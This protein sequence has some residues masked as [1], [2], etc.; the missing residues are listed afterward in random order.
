MTPDHPVTQ[1]RGART[2]PYLMM[3]ALLFWGWQSGYWQAG[4]VM[5]IVLEGA[6][7][8]RTRWDVSEEDFRR[9]RN[10]CALLGLALVVYIFSTNEAGGGV[11]SLFGANTLA[12]TRY[13]G[14]SAT[15][16]LRW[17]PIVL[18]LFVAAEFYSERQAVPLVAISWFLRNLRKVRGGSERTMDI[19]YPYF[20][21]CLFSASIHM[22]EGDLSYFWGQS[23]LVAWALWP[24]RTVRF[25]VVAWG[26]ALAAAIGL[27]LV[28]QRGL[29]ELQR[30]IEGY[31]AQ[32]MANLMRPRTIPAQ[33]E[34]AM[35][36][37]GKLKLSPRI[38]IRLET[39]TGPA[40]DYL[41]EATY[42]RYN[43]QQ[44]AWHAGIGRTDF[45]NVP[46]EPGNETAW[47][48][49]RGKTNSWVVT[50]AA[51]MDGRSRDTG[52]PEGLLPLPTGTYRL[53]KLPVFL[54]KK[55]DNGELLAAGLGLVNFDA[56]Y[57]AGAT[58]DSRPDSDT[59]NK[60][61]LGVPANEAPAL[62]RII[63][64]MNLRGGASENEK[65]NVVQQFFN[66]QFK[67]STWLG[68][69]KTAGANETV[70][71]RFLLNSRSG[72]CEY[73]A[74]ATVLLLRE[75]RIPARYAVGYFVH[76]GAGHKYVVRERDAHAWCLVCNV[77]KQMWENFDTTPAS[78]IP[79]EA[80]RA[81]ATQW[82]S[83]AWSWIHF[84]F[85]KLRW[86]Q[87]NLREYLLWALIPVLAILLYQ[88]IFRRRRK[89]GSQDKDAASS[90]TLWPGLDSEFYQLERKLA[91]RGVPRQPGEPLS[92]W[93]ARPLSDPA[94]AGLR[95]PLEELLR[96]H[97]G[98]RFDPRGLSPEQR[99]SLAR[100]AKN[101]LDNLVQLERRN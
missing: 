62:D 52:D 41:R 80:A 100:E 59:T 31:N 69:D 66:S 2:P 99:A 71:S 13:V 79:E 94:L 90:A 1:V 23:V 35:G 30:V 95:G 89:L 54:L 39:K 83:D 57:G 46:H 91:A 92:G 15:A 65:L 9:I 33:T 26:T 63:S 86:G 38:V 37:I 64:E 34:T 58:F 4:A 49:I 3:A 85:S 6:R 42:R 45:V 76:E 101:I 77:S 55:N 88:I 70:L 17:L 21:V 28:G 10:F 16:F 61:D 14:L 11:S 7:F 25:G 53:E 78:W 84:Q 18:F 29:S 67:Y 5:G 48:L 19:S 12:A 22:S 8:N 20:M 68:P 51:Y 47:A 81:P 40:P 87:A 72:H 60:F 74:T 24:R 93:L 73:F 75:M 32:W 97:Y 96:L 43:S 36:Q 50:I 82:L 44:P 27:G 98:Y 56:F